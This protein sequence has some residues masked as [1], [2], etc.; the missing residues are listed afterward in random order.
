M[1]FHLSYSRQLQRKPLSVI[2]ASNGDHASFAVQKTMKGKFGTCLSILF[3]F[4][5]AIW[6]PLFSIFLNV[7]YHR[8][9]PSSIWCQ[10][11]NPRPL[12]HEPSA[13]T[14]RPVFLNRGSV[15]PQGSVGSSKGSAKFENTAN[16]GKNLC[17]NTYTFFFRHFQQ[18]FVSV[19]LCHQPIWRE[20]H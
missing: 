2:T 17:F 14:T 11:L 7:R 10:G 8:L 18:K 5:C 12:G 1:M 20:K 3:F 13:L 6:L 4:V 15:E 16:F 19:Y 9:H